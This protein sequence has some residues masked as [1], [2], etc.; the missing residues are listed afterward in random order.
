M[1]DEDS[2]DDSM[3]GIK[4]PPPCTRVDVYPQAGLHTLG[5]FKASNVLKGFQLTLKKLDHEWAANRDVHN[6]IISG[7]SCQG[8]NHAQHCLTDRA[9]GIKVLHGQLTAAMA[10]V[11]G[12]THCRQCRDKLITQINTSLP[13]GLISCKLGKSEISCVF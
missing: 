7:L 12:D 3:E 10:R 13:F 4:K 9:G 5:H 11:Q 1:D 2:E 8:Y 6:P